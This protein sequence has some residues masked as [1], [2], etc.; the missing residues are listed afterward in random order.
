MIGITPLSENTSSSSGRLSGRIAVIT[1]AS[2]GIGRAVAKAYAAEGAQCI[3]VAR[4]IGGL[5]ELD[6]EIT[7]AG[8]LKP[9]LTPLDITQ[10]DALD[11]MGQALHE[12]FGKLDILV[13]NAGL[14][15]QISP[16][17]HIKPSDWEKTFAVNVTANFRLI[18]SLD[19]LLRQSDAGRAILVTSGDARSGKALWSLY[20][21]TK[22]ALEAM[23]MSYAAENQKFGL[24]ANLLS[25]GP[26]RTAMRA[27]AYPGEDPEP[28]PTPEELAPLFIELALPSCEKTG[29]IVDFQKR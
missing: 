23:V 20:G 18:R 4:T 25:P 6:D 22:A 27:K 29:E 1:G 13:G 9:V 2:R 7:G 10:F 11:A 3:L 19:P 24:K 14:L 28:L 16:V 26:I 21:A 5:E 15:G 17:G 12:R 8:G